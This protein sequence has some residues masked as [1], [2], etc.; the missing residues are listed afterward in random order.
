MFSFFPSLPISSFNL[1]YWSSNNWIYASADS[2]LFLVSSSYCNKLIFF[3]SNIRL[4]EAKL[5][6]ELFLYLFS[7]YFILSIF[8]F[9]YFSTFYFYLIIYSS[10]FILNFAWDSCY[11]SS[12]WTGIDLEELNWDSWAF[13][14][15][16]YYWSFSMISLHYSI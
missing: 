3:S 13:K 16:N 1:C 2:S 6:T 10:L 12:P 4:F 14:S 8:S 9:N 7:L 15:S 5:S 11:S